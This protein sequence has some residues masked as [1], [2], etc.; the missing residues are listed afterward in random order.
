MRP[1]VL[2]NKSL[3]P[4]EMTYF[5]SDIALQIR[6]HIMRAIILYF[7]DILRSKRMSYTPN[8]LLFLEKKTRDLGV[9]LILRAEFKMRIVKKKRNKKKFITSFSCQINWKHYIWWQLT[10]THTR[11][12][13]QEWRH[14]WVGQKR[15]NYCECFNFNFNEFFSNTIHS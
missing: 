15:G 11:T 14:Q 13:I 12:Q 5:Q 4:S 1:I 10:H 8:K 2:E 3:S 9:M 7:S 6:Q